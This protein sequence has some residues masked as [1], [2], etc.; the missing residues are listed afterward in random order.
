MKDDF[1]DRSASD[2]LPAGFDPIEAMRILIEYLR[3]LETAYNDLL[4]NT[5]LHQRQT[6]ATLRAAVKAND[7]LELEKDRL[8]KDL[9]HLSNRVEELESLQVT[10]HQKIVNYEQQ[11]KKLYTENERLEHQ[12]VKKENDN[13]FYLSEVERLTR[14]YEAVNSS[15]S[16][17]N[18]RADDLERKLA[19]ERN[20]VMTYE[21]ENR[22]LSSLLSEARSKN[23]ILEGKLTE[24]SGAHND[25]VRKLNDKLRSDAKHEIN[26]LKKQVKMAINPEL[27]D[28]EKLSK[29]KLSGELASNLKALMNRFISKLE[30]VGFEL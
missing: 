8:T 23:Q 21:K 25:E 14:D 10:T 28:L 6:E 17:V 15:V 13:N 4:K 30:Q 7:D 19:A 24:L 26:L 29:E 11:S 20:Q 5:T 3:N 16:S 12:L 18:N 27:E 9:L 1:L 22:R 2:L